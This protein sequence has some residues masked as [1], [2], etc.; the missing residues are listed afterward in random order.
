MKT[1]VLTAVLAFSGVQCTPEPVEPRPNH[2]PD[3]T[4]ISA[5]RNAALLGCKWGT[6][7]PGDDG[8]LGTED[9]VTCPE[10]CDFYEREGITQMVDCKTAAA[11][12]SELA[13]CA[14]GAQ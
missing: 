11:S 12:C 13:M 1:L 7:T 8:E 14:E 6:I 2:V 5:C 3:S 9:D 10:R 4:C